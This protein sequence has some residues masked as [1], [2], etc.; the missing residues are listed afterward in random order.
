MTEPGGICHAAGV[1]AWRKGVLTVAGVVVVA[2]VGGSI[3]FVNRGDEP[4]DPRLPRA[5]ALGLEVTPA[6]LDGAAAID[7]VPLDPDDGADPDPEAEVEVEAGPTID[8]R[9]T[10]RLGDGATYFVGYEITEALGILGATATGTTG[11]YTGTLVIEAGRLTTL[12]LTVDLRTLRSDEAFRDELIRTEVLQTDLYPDATF[13]ADVPVELPASVA[14]GAPFSF[15]ITG[16]LTLRDIAGPVRFSIEGRWQGDVVELAGTISFA[17]PNYG[18]GSVPG[19]VVAIRD[20][21]EI[22]FVV[23]FTAADA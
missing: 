11:T 23:A 9:R 14:V 5:G 1:A 4:L 6:P 22:G 15:D 20:D 8:G 3:W 21:A 10:A 19:G 16:T 2:V 17:L 12:D 18:I 7:A 13:V